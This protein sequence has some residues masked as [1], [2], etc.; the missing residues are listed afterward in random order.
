MAWQGWDLQRSQMPYITQPNTCSLGG[1]E[2]TGMQHAEC[3]K[4]ILAFLLGFPYQTS[5]SL[6]SHKSYSFTHLC[7]VLTLVTLSGRQY[8]S[9]L[10]TTVT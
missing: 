1:S 9:W 4:P 10:V 8:H 5:H 2:G 3:Y 6:W 7:L